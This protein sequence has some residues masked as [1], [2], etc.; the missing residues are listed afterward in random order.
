MPLTNRTKLIRRLKQALGI[1]REDLEQCEKKQEQSLPEPID[2]SR[3]KKSPNLMRL[4]RIV[5]DE[6]GAGIWGDREVFNR[7][8]SYV[9]EQLHRPDVADSLYWDG[10]RIK[11]NMSRNLMLKH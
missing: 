11:T 5:S 4:K 10:N 9:R 6:T 1:I 3:L 8:D 2:A 7:L